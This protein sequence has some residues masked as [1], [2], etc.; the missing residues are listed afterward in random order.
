MEEPLYF[1]G[2]DL[3]IDYAKGINSPKE[4]EPNN[5]LFFV[6]CADG[7]VALKNILAG[8]AQNI[9]SIYFCM[10]YFFQRSLQQSEIFLL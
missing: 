8:H 3:V 10:L 4:V 5:R 9:I 1:G 2:R 6:G 7:E